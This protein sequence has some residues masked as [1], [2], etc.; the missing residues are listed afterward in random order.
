M[1]AVHHQSQMA[2]N[3]SHVPRPLSFIESPY[4]SVTNWLMRL[5]RF[6]SEIGHP[7]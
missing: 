4:L 3:L 7:G 5:F 1:L 6:E 2:F